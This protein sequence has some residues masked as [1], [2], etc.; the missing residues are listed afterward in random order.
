MILLKRFV[1]R[2]AWPASSPVPTA[3][4][5]VGDGPSLRVLFDGAL[6]L[7]PSLTKGRLRKYHRSMARATVELSP[8]L[9]Q[10]GTRFG[11]AAWGSHLVRLVGFPLPM[12]HEAVENCIAP[13]GGDPSSEERCGWRQRRH[14][15]SPGQPPVDEQRRRARAPPRSRPAARERSARE[16]ECARSEPRPDR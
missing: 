14:V 1:G 4:P 12:P 7:E 16:P 15:G 6:S 10:D 9:A 13:S 5:G 2:S 3:V 11:P 8:E